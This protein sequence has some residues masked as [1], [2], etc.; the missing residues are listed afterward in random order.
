[1]IFVTLFY[2]FLI[3]PNPAEANCVKVSGVN[4]Q[5]VNY[6]PCLPPPPKVVS[7]TDRMSCFDIVVNR[8]TGMVVA[9]GQVDGYLGYAFGDITST[10]W[11]ITLSGGPTLYTETISGNPSSAIP[12]SSV[13][14]F[15]INS[16]GTYILTATFNGPGGQAQLADWCAVNLVKVTCTP[17]TPYGVHCY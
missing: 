14:D 3:N 7:V 9:A 13:R 11:T 12:P 8:W 2:Y 4:I 5:N 15:P 16:P 17:Q 6:Q 10:T 1:M